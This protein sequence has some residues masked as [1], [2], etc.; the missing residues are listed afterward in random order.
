MKRNQINHH[1]YVKAIRDSDISIYD[2]IAVNDPKLWIP[3]PILETLL[4]Q[5]LKGMSVRNLPI[6]T[7]SKVVKQAICRVLGYP[8]PKS[9]K[10]T[11]P[12]FPGQRFDTYIQ[13]S[14]NLQIWNEEI[15]P[16][17]RY[18]II[19][20][21]PDDEIE[22]VK[23]TTGEVLAKLDKTGT[24]TRKYQAKIVPGNAPAELVTP[25]DTANLRSILKRHNEPTSFECQPADEPTE[26]TLLPITVLFERLKALVGYT[27]AD[28]G[29]DQERLR[30]AELHRLVCL[31]LGYRDYQDT[32]SFPDIPNQL[33][34]VKLQTSLTIDLGLICPDSQ[35]L[36]N[37]P[38]IGSTE[39]R[40][41]DV[42][43]VI[44]YAS[45]DGRHIQ[46]THVYLTTGEAFFQR[47]PQFQGQVVNQKL[48]IPL[49]EDF[50]S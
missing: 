2:P 49:P 11:Q 38:P 36:L 9:F 10:R 20:V 12:R 13:K 40:H 34:E 22:R 14:N 3:N 17:R 4:E 21:S 46:L 43:Y 39:I 1:A 24:L 30:G 48:Q 15:A 47:F 35:K 45:T 26:D 41:C 6:R 8:I 19:R 5:G 31:K 44:F 27:F 18:V 16:E 50:F 32:G 23:V 42:R 25:E 29:S 28:S 7:R 37:T 33:L